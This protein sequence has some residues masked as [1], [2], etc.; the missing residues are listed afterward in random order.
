[1]IIN[2]TVIPD[3]RF[4]SVDGQGLV[5][6][7]PAAAN[8]HAIQWHNGSGHVEFSDGLTPNLIIQG[9]EDYEK[10]VCPYVQ[11]WEEIYHNVTTAEQYSDTPEEKASVIRQQRD[12]LLS[13]TDYLMMPDYPMSE[14]ARE[15][16]KV[17]RQA[18]RDVPEQPGFP[19]SVVWPIK[20]E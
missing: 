17:Y 12:D 1:M 20:G 7:Y 6:D 18:L 10:Y 19:N 4:I 11:M 2:L 13:E 16:L 5:F 15:N 3:D 14:L 9:Q 8:I